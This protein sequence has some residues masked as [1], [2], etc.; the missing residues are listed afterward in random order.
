MLQRLFA[1]PL[2]DDVLADSALMDLFGQ[3]ALE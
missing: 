2:I 1:K 3:G